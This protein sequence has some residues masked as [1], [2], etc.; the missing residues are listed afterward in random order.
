MN[1]P[2]SPTF[3]CCDD[4]NFL[5]W[6]WEPN[7]LL[8]FCVCVFLDKLTTHECEGANFL[9]VPVL[10]HSWYH[11]R[12]TLRLENPANEFREPTSSLTVLSHVWKTSDHELLRSDSSCTTCIQRFQ[13]RR[14]TATRSFVEPELASQES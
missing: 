5:S 14:N 11:Q 12:R 6:H 8:P 1:T 3:C 9:S 13:N 2:I 10:P 7:V 4:Q